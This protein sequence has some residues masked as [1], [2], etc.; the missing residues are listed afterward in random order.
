MLRSFTYNRVLILIFEY[1]KNIH[2]YDSI[3]DG[4]IIY[5]KEYIMMVAYG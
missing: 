5:M 4:L 2:V 3:D 1:K